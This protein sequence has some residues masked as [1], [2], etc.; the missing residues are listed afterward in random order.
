MINDRFSQPCITQIL[1]LSQTRTAG[2]HPRLVPIWGFITWWLQ[3]RWHHKI[4][5]HLATDLYK[6]TCFSIEFT[7]H[8]LPCVERR[9]V[10]GYIVS[11]LQVCCC[12]APYS[13]N[14]HV[15]K[16]TPC[17]P[18][19]VFQ[20]FLAVAPV[21]EKAWHWEFSKSLPLLQRKFLLLE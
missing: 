18:W 2:S 9:K 4:N 5:S 20:D 1:S 6:P 13:C 7:S 3:W 15:R 21:C 11:P 12:A 14:W 17:A 10:R 19:A 16:G 8:I